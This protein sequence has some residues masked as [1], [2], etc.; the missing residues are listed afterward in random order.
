[1]IQ[2]KTTPEP[3]FEVE[4]D[5]VAQSAML[6]K[7]PGVK[8]VTHSGGNTWQLRAGAGIDLRGDL[9]EFAVK[10]NLKVL[11][12]QRTESSLEDVFHHLTGKN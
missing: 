1:V 7:I 5:S 2:Q 12:L 11:T 10:N 8:K 4:F 9:F 3:V 6:S